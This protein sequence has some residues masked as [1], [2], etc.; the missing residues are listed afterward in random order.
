MVFGKCTFDIELMGS[1]QLCGPVLACLRLVH[2]AVDLFEV[3]L[4]S[5]EDSF[6]ELDES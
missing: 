1:E 5:G 3:E 4:L 2:R 6:H